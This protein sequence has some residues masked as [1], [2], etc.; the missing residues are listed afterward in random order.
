[1]ASSPGLLNVSRTTRWETHRQVFTQCSQCRSFGLLWETTGDNTPHTGVLK[2]LQVSTQVKPVGTNQ[3]TGELYWWHQ[4]GSSMCQTPSW[5]GVFVLFGLKSST[6]N[7]QQINSDT[8]QSQWQT[9][10]RS[11]AYLLFALLSRKLLFNVGVFFTSYRQQA[12]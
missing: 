1:M 4:L 8:D 10:N 9:A 7:R 2:T 6:L 12:K 11:V 3:L 5:V